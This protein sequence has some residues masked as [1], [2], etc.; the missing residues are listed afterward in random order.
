MHSMNGTLDERTVAYIL[1]TRPP[2]E[3]LRQV[4]S[5]LAGLLVLAASGAKSAAPDHPMLNAA[6]QTFERAADEIRRA[7][8]T[9]RSRS[10]HRH[11]LSAIEAIDGALAAALL[12]LRGDRFADVEAMLMPLKAGY[13]QLQEAAGRLPGFELV[14]L[15]QGCCAHGAGGTARAG[16]SDQSA[17]AGIT[18]RRV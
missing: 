12:H 16:G 11:M 6:R 10:H 4:A 9:V 18:E 15:N 5:Q 14:A 7:R 8:P 2:F 13:L 1:Q 17:G 3:D